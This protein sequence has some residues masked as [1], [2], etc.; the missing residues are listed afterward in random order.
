MR[1][2]AVVG[3][4][5]GHERRERRSRGIMKRSLDRQ[6]SLFVL[7]LFTVLL[8]APAASIE[9]SKLDTFSASVHA[10]KERLKKRIPT[11]EN[12]EQEIL[13]LQ[14]LL[15]SAE[16]SI[17]AKKT[18]AKKHLEELRKREA[19]LHR[20]QVLWR[21]KAKEAERNVEMA[22]KK[23]AEA[24]KAKE[25]AQVS[26]QEAYNL[27]VSYKQYEEETKVLKTS[28][29]QLV[30]EAKDADVELNELKNHIK[31]LSLSSRLAMARQVKARPAEGLRRAGITAQ[32]PDAG[33]ANVNLADKKLKLFQANDSEK[34]DLRDPSGQSANGIGGRIDVDPSSEMCIN[35]V[36]PAV[37]GLRDHS[38]SA[39]QQIA[40][41][42]DF[43]SRS[44]E[45]LM[46]RGEPES[47]EV[48]YEPQE[49]RKRSSKRHKQE[50]LVHS[51][52]DSMGSFEPVAN[53]PNDASKS[54]KVKDSQ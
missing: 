4:E 3:A 1:L 5:K 37:D 54:K 13:E 42:R 15:T 50:T 25:L 26:S 49:A 27:E 24:I 22:R 45:D 32:K 36:L 43:H 21:S 44:S 51:L 12:N 9:P 41:Q 35:A 52:N 30:E 2:S 6:V 19:G 38:D 34:N 39:D 17:R 20:S 10:L 48:P 8:H 14:N 18:D 53:L 7:T 23:E 33:H 29:S 46:V 31:Q 16:N 47:K 28:I 11:G 40:N